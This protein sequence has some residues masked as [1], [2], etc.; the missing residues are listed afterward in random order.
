[1]NWKAMFTRV[2]DLLSRKFIVF[3]IATI[4]V[5]MKSIEGWM[6]VVIAAEYLGINMLQKKL[7]EG[8]LPDVG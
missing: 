7:L 2:Q 3:V 5:F 6:W 8:K 4:L 1:M